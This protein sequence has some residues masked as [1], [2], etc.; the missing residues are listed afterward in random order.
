MPAGTLAPAHVGYELW[1]RAHPS[2]LGEARAF[3]DQQ[4]REF[5][6]GEE[7]RYGLTFAVNEAVSNAIEHGAPSRDGTVKICA[8]EEDR[9]LAFYVWDWGRFS[10]DVPVPQ[11]LPER[12]RGLAFMAALVDEVDLRREG[13]ATVVR[14]AKCR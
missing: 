4:A 2:E 3:A 12:G 11:A 9:A 8:V 1:L 5:G 10:P 13:E 14:L 7:Q 6:F